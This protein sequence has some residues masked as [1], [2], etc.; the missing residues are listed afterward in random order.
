MADTKFMKRKWQIATKEKR[1]KA[2]VGKR[3]EKLQLQQMFIV[4]QEEATKKKNTLK[5]KAGATNAKS[6]IESKHPSTSIEPTFPF[7]DVCS[8]AYYCCWPKAK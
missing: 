1:R 3:I 5:K 6:A 4:W 7:E 2:K 8:A